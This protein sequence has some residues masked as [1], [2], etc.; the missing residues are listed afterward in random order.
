MSKTTSI[1]A[2]LSSSVEN[3]DLDW[4]KD[5]LQS[6]V[7]LEHATLPLYLSTMFSLEVQNYTTYNLIRSVVME[8]M[9][10][11]A[12]SCNILSAL[13]GKPS[14]KNLSPQ[15][16][17][18]GLPGGAEPDLE[19]VLARL[20]IPQ[21]K[22]FM[23]LES[24]TYLLPEEFKKE[25]YPSIGT[26]YGG[27]K[28]AIT[29]NADEVRETVRKVLSAPA[30]TYSNQV[31]DNIGFTT[32]QL[33]EDHPDNTDE[34]DQLI[35]GIN[36]IIEQ[37]EGSDTGD[38]WAES[39]EDEESHYA[40]F[41]EIYYGARLQ[42]L[43]GDIKLS[44]ETEPEFFKGH[45]ISWPV[46]TNT[47]AIPSDGYKALLKSYSESDPNNKDLK[48]LSDALDGFDETYTGIMND[49]DAMWNGPAAE[50]W[51]KFGAAV[52]AMMEMRV[53]S[54]FYIMRYEVPKKLVEDLSTI[55]PNEYD[56]LSRY[57]DLS[58]PVFFG[59]RFINNNA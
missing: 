31:G 41:G 50:S 11:M 45:K 9:V 24:P 49:L 6:A 47:L 38:L 27:L 26:I 22:N 5:V 30:D 33:K 20:S 56:L 32:I 15:L 48:A 1:N 16:P 19:V 59:P 2:Y 3:R 25:E 29:Q 7:E 23:R 53:K 51:P 52:G 12:I 4:I 39:F 13:G 54:C 44:R 46:V 21:L 43:E 17:G 14:I 34:V 57:T 40:R 58:T 36:E 35:N 10:H 8:E 18:K 28:E 55:Y 42:K 37:G